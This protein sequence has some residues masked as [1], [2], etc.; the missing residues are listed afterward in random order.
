MP[1]ADADGCAA[2]RL[3]QQ[4]HVLVA[5]GDSNTRTLTGAAEALDRV[6]HWDLT[7]S[8]TGPEEFVS[9]RAKHILWADRSGCA[10]PKDVQVCASV[11]PHSTVFD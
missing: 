5:I 4:L 1:A 9:G 7:E 10:V 8:P 3:R 11:R 2:N 6:A